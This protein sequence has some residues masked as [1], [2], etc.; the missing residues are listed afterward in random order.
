MTISINQTLEQ[1]VEL[2]QE[3]VQRWEEEYG[4]A[5]EAV[6]WREIRM[7]IEP[8][9]KICSHK[10]ETTQKMTQTQTERQ[11]QPIATADTETLA[12]RL[13]RIEKTLTQLGT[14]T[15]T[16]QR[17][18]S[19]SYAAALQK[20]SPPQPRTHPSHPLP[21][22]PPLKSKRNHST[23]PTTA[24]HKIV[25]Q[26]NDTQEKK[27]VNDLPII[28][29]VDKANLSYTEKK[30]IAARKLPS[31]EIAIFAENKEAR[32]ELQENTTW[33]KSLSLEAQIKTRAYE[34]LLKAMTV[35]DEG[36]EKD[37]AKALETE[38]A[39][40][41]PGLRIVR[42]KWLKRNRAKGDYSHMVIE[43]PCPEI[44]NRAI[45]QGLVH[46][47]ELKSVARFDRTMRIKQ[48]YK[49][50]GYGHLSHACH[51]YWTC[52]HCAGNHR[53][54][55]C[56]RKQERN[57]VRCGTCT[58]DHKAWSP[59]CPARE[60]AWMKIRQTHKD[61]AQDFAIS[62]RNTTTPPL[63][64]AVTPSSSPS[65]LAITSS[66]TPSPL[67]S[68]PP[69]S[70]PLSSPLPADS[71]QASPVRSSRGHVSDADTEWSQVEGSQ[72]RKMAR[73]RGR[74][75]GSRNK[76]RKDTVRSQDITVLFT[77]S[78]AGPTTQE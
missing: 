21:Q 46:N 10:R 44:A 5:E 36:G 53:T 50:Q 54:A 30:V 4:G 55:A 28:E 57:A 69:P 25:V 41:I 13:D 76:I 42:L 62:V 72:K 68:F 18:S 64:T 65:M 24:P 22:N 56:T 74:P 12:T 7:L 47:M 31:G 58:G 17:A 34:V 26:I 37:I 2:I 40:L 71:H 59:D 52:G 48:C 15:P 14:R 43:L 32:T 20:P 45:Q 23:M 60:R 1:A 8:I 63:A 77:G 61:K 66:S 49:C 19:S 9:E 38:N 35:G 6:P 11:S 3:T 33:V 16:Q 70:T 75:Q 27:R 51:G 73:S 67:P 78:Q 29:I 39:R